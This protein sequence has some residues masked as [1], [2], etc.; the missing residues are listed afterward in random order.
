MEVFQ[1][2]YVLLYTMWHARDFICTTFLRKFN[3]VILWRYHGVSLVL[4]CISMT[5]WYCASFLE[6]MVNYLTSYGK[7]CWLHFLLTLLSETGVAN[8]FQQPMDCLYFLNAIFIKAAVFDFGEVKC[9][10]F[11]V[12]FCC[13]FLT[14]SYKS[15][16]LIFCKGFMDFIWTFKSMIHLR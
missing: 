3:S 8:I 4:L 6:F 2:V 1:S 14:Q 5:A 7:C 15:F 13:I 12:I 11:I 9:I 16:L 10:K